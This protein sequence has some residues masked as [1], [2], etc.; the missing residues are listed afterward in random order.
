MTD[1]LPAILTETVD[2]YYGG[3]V[4]RLAEELGLTM[5]VVA[6]AIKGQAN[7]GP[8]PLLTLARITGYAYP[9]LLRV[10]GHAKL[11]AG[12]EAYYGKRPTLSAHDHT[13]LRRVATLDHDERR[14]IEQAV[15]LLRRHSGQ[16]QS[17]RAGTPDRVKSRL[18]L[19]Q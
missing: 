3:I 1:K 5:S 18:H 4:T 10:A 15:N 12:L 19:G 6:R 8:E 11:A 7:L 13:L 16:I 14:L 9:D 2:R 17:A